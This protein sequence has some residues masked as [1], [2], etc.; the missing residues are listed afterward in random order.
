MVQPQ[1]PKFALENLPLIPVHEWKNVLINDF[2]P[3]LFK[4]YP[5]I[6]EIK[7]K[8]YAI[9]AEYASMSGSGSAVY[10]LFKEKAVSSPFYNC[11]TWKG[12]L[13]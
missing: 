13:A 5:I 9:G 2:E 12:M 10:G 1:K 6:K 8:L 7:E 11:F 3:V 4:K